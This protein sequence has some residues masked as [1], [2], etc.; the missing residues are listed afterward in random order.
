MKN[1][2]I[3]KLKGIWLVII[4]GGLIIGFFG[5]FGYQAYLEGEWLGLFKYCGV[6][7]FSAITVWAVATYEP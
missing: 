2:L 4:I 1:K 3:N 6:L 7:C 5:F